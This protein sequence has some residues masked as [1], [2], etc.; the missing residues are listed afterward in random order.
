MSSPS[1]TDR[2][3]A[4]PS[5]DTLEA[6]KNVRWVLLGVMLALL[7][8]MLDGLIVGTAMPTVVAD[9]GGL[10][11]M[12]WVVTGYTL[13]TACSTPVWGKLGDLF[14][15]KT[16][17]LA[18]IAL[19]L[20]ASVLCGVAGSMNSLIV[21]RVIQGVGAGGMGAG[22]FALIG[23]LLPPRERGKY[24]GMVAAVMA[25][26][27]LGGPL[28]GGFVTGHLGWRWA[29]FINI[30]IGIVCIAWCWLLLRV[31]ATRRQ[32]DAGM[33]WWGITF[34]TGTISAFVIAATW[35]GSTYAWG[36]WQI[37]GLAV[38]AVA[39]LAAFIATEQRVKEPL[40][41]LRIYS[42]HRNF[43]LAASLITVNGVAMF[44]ATLYLPLYQQ[45][46]QGASAVNSGLLL[47]PMM[48]ASLITSTIAGKVMTSTGRYKASPVIGA[49]LLVIGMGLLST[50][51]TDTSRFTT[52][53]FMAIVGAGT[54]LSLQMSTT[55]AQ[56]A[57][58]LRDIGAASA[59]TT[60]F[61][62]LGGSIGIAVFA[63]LFTNAFAGSSQ[64]MAGEGSSSGSA[65][66]H[67]SSAAHD[68]YLHEVANA[69][70]LIFLTGACIALV[71]LVA[72]VFI[73]EVPLRGKPAE[74]ASAPAQSPAAPIG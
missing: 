29:F 19:F 5:A 31:P 14:N 46:V 26:G 49:I 33:D 21:F 28:L 25:I 22:A 2:P 40:M 39:L 62:S 47:L 38:T 63:S 37:I 64:G 30:P 10:N 41:P 67:L 61:R 48:I 60:L 66:G 58:G 72:S 54:G 32:D 34:L 23:A 1:G 13:A 74:E 57:V 9:L 20:V 65:T 44:G 4:V 11:H 59:A 52:S 7:L 43:P 70:H 18:S 16:A 12:S 69:T 71:A 15:R 35:A 42:G 3:G 50:M 55:I 68:L 27:Q 24:Q 45:V 17:F 56:N 6:P 51:G 53:A 36:S 73:K 8:S